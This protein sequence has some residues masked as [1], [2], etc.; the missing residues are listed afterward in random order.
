M[1]TLLETHDYVQYDRHRYHFMATG[2]RLEEER[3]RFKPY[4]DYFNVPQERV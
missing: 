4:M 1:E 3:R 2:L